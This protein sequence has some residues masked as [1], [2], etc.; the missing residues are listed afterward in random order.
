M[1]RQPPFKLTPRREHT[2]TPVR[3]NTKASGNGGAFLL[4]LLLPF[5][6][7]PIPSPSPPREWKRKEYTMDFKWCEPGFTQQDSELALCGVQRWLGAL[8]TAAFQSAPGK[9]RCPREQTWRGKKQDL[10]LL[11]LRVGNARRG[12][13]WQP[14]TLP[15]RFFSS[16]SCSLSAGRGGE[17]ACRAGQSHTAVMK[18]VV[19][20]PASFQGHR[21]TSK[22][23]SQRCCSHEE[24]LLALL[25]GWSQ[26]KSCSD[27]CTLTCGW[28]TAVMLG[29][30]FI[31]PMNHRIPG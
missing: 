28:G 23:C 25:Q 31:V 6:P 30:A 1:P 8:C 7:E 18:E 24:R 16:T 11:C 26:H 29:L 19:L 5:V 14:R 12:L 22:C 21:D 2:G 20:A 17:Q 13:G 10:N 27:L 3:G 15:C 4:F 9:P